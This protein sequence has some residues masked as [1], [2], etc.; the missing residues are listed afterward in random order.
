[1]LCRKFEDVRWNNTVELQVDQF[2]F[3]IKK[4]AAPSG[5][6]EEC[7]APDL[8]SKRHRNKQHEREGS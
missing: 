3:E 2:A 1:M 7:F 5:D 8:N 4:I 6:Q